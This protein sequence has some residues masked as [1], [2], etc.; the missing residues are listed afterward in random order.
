M[1]DT[2]GLA[3]SG[4]VALLVAPGCIPGSGTGSDGGEAV[5]DAGAAPADGG[6]LD[7]CPMSPAPGSPV[8]LQLS[9]WPW[10]LPP[11]PLFPETDGPAGAAAELVELAPAPTVLQ[12][13]TTNAMGSVFFLQ[14]PTFYGF[15]RVS[16]PGFKRTS[17]YYGHPITAAWSGLGRSFPIVTE[18]DWPTLHAL[19]A[20]AED[21]TTGV[22]VGEVPSGCC[23]TLSLD[24]GGAL[25][26]GAGTMPDPGASWTDEDGV[27]Y[28]FG[29]PAGAAALTATNGTATTVVDLWI[30]PGEAHFVDVL[31]P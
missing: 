23:T 19:A 31:Y 29:V 28:V 20:Q 3:R 10:R 30:Y 18:A 1:R 2:K 21:P 13:G 24:M 14:E 25:I 8:C 5:A 16:S 12:T 4:L 27:F 15:A 17:Y 6:T 7:E 11:E 9:P 22:I 26:Y